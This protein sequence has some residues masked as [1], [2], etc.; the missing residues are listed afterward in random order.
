M[1]NFKFKFQNVLNFKIEVEEK[2]KNEFV[3]MF[4]NYLIQEKRLNE[5]M[6]RKNAAQ[7]KK[8]DIKSGVDCIQYARYLSYLE[9]L[10]DIQRQNLIKAK[11]SMEKAKEELLKSISDRKVLEKLKEKAKEEFD[12][13]ENKKEQ[14]LNDDFALF[15]YIRSERR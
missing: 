3:K 6:E 11:D 8:S 12:F 1:E 2:K 5:L 14:S 13:Y 9:N 7:G 15:S 10:I 4:K